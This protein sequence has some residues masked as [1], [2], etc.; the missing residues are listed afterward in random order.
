[1]NVLLDTN[2]LVRMAQSGLPN[3]RIATEACANLQ[4]RGDVPSLVP[5]VIYELW[6]VL[7][8][9][10]TV[11]G[12]GLSSAQAEVEVV[13]LKSNFHFFSDTSDVFTEWERLVTSHKVTGKK[14]HDARLVAA[15]SV[16]GLSHLLSFN[17]SDFTRYPGVTAL[18]PVALVP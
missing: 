3:Q 14:A 7:T 5:Q 9:P 18:D 6:V 12:L 16:H 17:F 4:L 8:R 10:I 13:R 11:N 15:M 1:M 2:I